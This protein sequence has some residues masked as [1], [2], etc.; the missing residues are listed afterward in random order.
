MTKNR[1]VFKQTG[2]EIFEV[3]TREGPRR[4]KDVARLPEVVR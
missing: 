1:L 3:L 4:G 2:K